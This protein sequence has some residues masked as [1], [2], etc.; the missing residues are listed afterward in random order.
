MLVKKKTFVGLAI[1]CVR[2]CVCMRARATWFDEVVGFPGN[3]FSDEDWTT[4]YTCRI[5]WVKVQKR[6]SACELF[7]SILLIAMQLDTDKQ[8]ALTDNVG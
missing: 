2:V 3:S 5:L 6:K 4:S 1:V 8:S 7:P